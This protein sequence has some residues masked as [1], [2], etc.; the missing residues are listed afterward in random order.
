MNSLAGRR[1]KLPRYVQQVKA[2][3]RVYWYLRA[4]G[5]ERMKLE[6]RS[7]SAPGRPASSRST[8]QP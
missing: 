1:A 2:G 7:G 8:M 4:P 6:I 3:E 5:R